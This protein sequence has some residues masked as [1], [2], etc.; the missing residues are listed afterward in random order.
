MAYPGRHNIYEATIRRMVQQSLELQEQAFSKEHEADT[1]QQLLMYLRTHAIRLNHSP[2]PGEIVGGS[3]I[4]ERLGSW[5]R[6]LMLAKLPE[7]RTPNKQKTFVRYQEEVEQQK[8]M[9]RQR[10]AE[11]KRLAQKRLVYQAAKKKEQHS[12]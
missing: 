8:E 1:D 7:P 2:W 11:K 4:E 12:K 6:A 9:Y 5:H 3:Y 10:K